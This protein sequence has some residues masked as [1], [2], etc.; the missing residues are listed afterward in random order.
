MNE[1]QR[2]IASCKVLIPEYS[3]LILFCLAGRA[4]FNITSTRTGVTKRFK[5]TP[6]NNKRPVNRWNVYFWFN[7]NWHYIGYIAKFWSTPGKVINYE[8]IAKGKLTKE[9]SGY[10][11]KWFWINLTGYCLTPKVKITRSRKCARCSRV[12]VDPESIKRGLGL[13]CYKITNKEIG[14]NHG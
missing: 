3:A 1:L 10:I 6:Y 12:L 14:I 9:V 8:F 11:F 7:N 4:I 5:I 13:H 2:L